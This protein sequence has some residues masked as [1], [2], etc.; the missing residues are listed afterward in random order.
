MTMP[1]HMTMS[2]RNMQLYP[3]VRSTLSLDAVLQPDLV[4]LK[5]HLDFF[6]DFDHYYYKCR[7]RHR[8]SP[9]YCWR[10]LWSWSRTHLCCRPRDP[11]VKI[12]ELDEDNK[13]KANV[14]AH[15][16]IVSLARGTLHG[17]LIEEGNVLVCV[18]SIEPGAE[19]VLLYEGNNN[20]NPPIV[21]LGNE[22]KSI[23]KKLIEALH[24]TLEES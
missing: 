9:H 21:R 5:C 18:S 7:R 16:I 1:L 11:I 2:Y 17:Q 15:D 24:A 3:S 12:F 22:L 20:D 10:P 13:A 23:T 4:M 6:L 19:F 14:V 8:I